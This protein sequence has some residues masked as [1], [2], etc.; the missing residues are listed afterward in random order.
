MTCAACEFC[1]HPPADAPLPEPCR[2]LASYA[3]PFNYTRHPSHTTRQSWRRRHENR[4]S[5]VIARQTGI[6]HDAVL[7]SGL[8]V[9]VAVHGPILVSYGEPS[10]GGFAQIG[11]DLVEEFERVATGS[12]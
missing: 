1:T 8:Q 5:K 12:A 9:L 11:A 2:A 3:H 6:G 10:F 4:G 7:R